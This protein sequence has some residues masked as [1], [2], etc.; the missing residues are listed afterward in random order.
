[1]FKRKIKQETAEKIIEKKLKNGET[2]TAKDI[3]LCRAI[4][5]NR[6]RNE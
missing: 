2:L 5:K 6:G 3:E 4:R 1:M